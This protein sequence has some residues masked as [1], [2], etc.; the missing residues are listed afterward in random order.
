[1]GDAITAVD[2]V[3]DAITAVDAVDAVELSDQIISVKILTES[4]FIEMLIS[5]RIH[6]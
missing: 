1:M 6:K 4:L 2:A 3:G 5:G